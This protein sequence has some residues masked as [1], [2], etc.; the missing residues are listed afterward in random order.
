MLIA[1]NDAPS[2]TA[3]L[4]SNQN[5]LNTAEAA[6]YTGLSTA[7]LEKLRCA[8]GGPRFIS[9]SRRAVRYRLADLDEW[10]AARTV[11]STSERRAA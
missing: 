9:Y 1:A 2:A 6:K 10:M 3:R 4:G 8:G 7:T 11:G 5:V